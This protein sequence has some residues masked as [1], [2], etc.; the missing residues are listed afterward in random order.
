[1]KLSKFIPEVGTP[2]SKGRRGY[3][4]D[5]SIGSFA[6]TYSPVRAGMYNIYLFGPIENATQF[7]GPIEVLNAAT[8]MDI[9]VIHLST[10]GGSLDAT[11]TFLQAMHECEGRVIVKASGGVHS[12]GSVIL[13]HAPE[14]TLSDNFNMLIH[15]GSCGAIDDFNK[16]IARS[17]FNEDY[18]NNVFRATYEGFLTPDEIDAMIEG[19]DYWITA[20]EFVRRWQNRNAY[21]E[22]REKGATAVEYDEDTVDVQMIHEEKPR[23]VRRKK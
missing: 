1:M 4:E 5:E 7:I 3:D 2:A 23:K 22:Q 17:K 11:D 15:N 14:F 19:K 6:V 18:M 20:E 10:P 16:F 21:F 8:D 9:V 12:A 13:L